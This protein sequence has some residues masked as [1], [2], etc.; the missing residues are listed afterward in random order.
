[1]ALKS[2][3]LQNSFACNLFIPFPAEEN[4]PSFP[5]VKIGNG[6]LL[7]F[8]YSPTLWKIHYEAIFFAQET[9]PVAACTATTEISRDKIYFLLHFMEWD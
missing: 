6:Y 9:V 2:L 5:A 8:Q 4:L 7:K 3:M 1:M